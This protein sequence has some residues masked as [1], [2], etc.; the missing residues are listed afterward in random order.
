[1][2]LQVLRNVLGYKYIFKAQVQSTSKYSK[3]CTPTL[4]LIAF[5]EEFIKNK[6]A[7]GEHFKQIA[8]K[9]ACVSDIL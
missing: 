1:M 8:P 2:Y 6:M 4:V 3:K 9:E 5:W 7:D